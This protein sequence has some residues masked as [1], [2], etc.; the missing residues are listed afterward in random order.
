MN[1]YCE[2]INYA[3]VLSCET[4]A[5]GSSIHEIRFYIDSDTFQPVAGQFVVLEPVDNRCIAP[6]PFT[7]V[8]YADHVLTLLINAVGTNTYGYAA[9]QSGEFVKIYGPYGTGITFDPNCTSC[10]F[11]GGGIGNAALPFPILTALRQKISVTVH[12]GAKDEG[13]IPALAQFD[14]IPVIPSTITENG[15]ACTGFVTQL[16]RETLHT[17]HGRSTVVACG[18]KNMLRAVYELCAQYGNPCIV[19]VEEIMACG[20]GACKGCAIFGGKE[21]VDV[22]H[23]CSDGPSFDA[24]WINWDKFVPRSTTLCID[25]AP[26]SLK[27]DDIDVRCNLCGLT[28]SSPFLNCSGTLDIDACVDGSMD[29]TGLGAFVIKGLSLDPRPGNLMPR[30]CETPSGMLNAIGLEYI[31]VQ[32]FIA[33]IL[34]RLRKLKIPIIANIN[35]VSIDEYRTLAERLND[36]EI[37][38]L[39]VNI[40]CPNVKAGGMVFGTDPHLAASVTSA[41]KEISRIPVIVKL[42]PNVTNIALI[43]KTVEDAGA[44]AVSLINTVLG[45]AVDIRH[46][47][48]RVANVF[49]GLSG[50]AIRPIAIRCVMQVANTIKIP[51]IGMGG[52]ENGYTAAEFMIAGATAT[53]F[54]TSGFANRTIFPQ[55]IEQ[56]R[57]IACFHGFSS[58]NELVKSM[59]SQS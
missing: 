50:P 4:E 17:D 45:A 25:D 57:E 14:H 36:T 37:A 42:T 34:P 18:P 8:S 16:L 5:F 22:L 35:G 28:L 6:R 2:K 56:L 48:P 24:Y 10:I 29:L 49:A 47:T 58:T 30:V 51:I 11:V 7:I 19:I 38:A 43:A 23:V 41:V 26:P 9:M 33:N 53:A 1:E 52:N 27:S 40:S 21:G 3:T 59:R 15:S 32:A 12:L 39:E 55:A 20:M 13:F 31:G 46:R 54:G 44:D